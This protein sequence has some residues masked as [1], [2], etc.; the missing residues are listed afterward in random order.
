MM[1]TADDVAKIIIAA[2]RETGADP[3]EVA[4]GELDP[5]SPDRLCPFPLA[6]ARVY[7][8]FAVSELFPILIKRKVARMCG[9]SPESAAS[10]HSAYG[11]RLSNLPWYS[12]EAYDRVLHA[13]PHADLFFDQ[14]SAPVSRYLPPSPSPSPNPNPPAEI[15]RRPA[16]S[17]G[18]RPAP[19]AEPG[20]RELY[21]MLE[22]A[23]SNTA[24]LKK[25]TDE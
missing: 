19:F 7:A 1:P 22:Q 25:P 16:E 4:L 13:I 5:K 15:E 8:V 10:F 14:E 11:Q 9:V 2:S 21:R 12:R 18:A 17:V 23:A 3:A 6:R 24:K 20:K